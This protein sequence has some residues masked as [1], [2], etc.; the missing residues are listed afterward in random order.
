MYIDGNKNT[1]VQSQYR[2]RAF[3]KAGAAVIFQFLMDP[4]L[5]NK[6][7]RLIAQYA[8]VSL[9]TM[10][11]VIAGLKKEGYLVQANIKTMQLINYEKLLHKWV[12]VLHEKLLPFQYL[13]RYTIL[14]T[15]VQQFFK[16][17]LITGN[18]QWGGE[19]A[20]A[21]LTNYLI[22]QKYTL[23][24]NEREELTKKYKL[25]PHPEGEIEVY[26]MFWKHSSYTK[27]HVHPVMIYA[28]LMA[29]GDSRNIETAEIIFNEHIKPNL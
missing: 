21:L 24:T 10:P 6:P 26:R 5:V 22:P 8:G 4:S 16:T 29:S 9:G 27:Q 18:T 15:T 17:N 19:P 12:D 20:A 28:Q 23:F 3:T 1:P 7:Q 11:K 14:K 13:Q 2:M 25:I